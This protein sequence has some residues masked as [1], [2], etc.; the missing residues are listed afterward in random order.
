MAITIEPSELPGQYTLVIE[1]ASVSVGSPTHCFPSYAGAGFV[2]VLSRERDPLLLAPVVE[3]HVTEHA[4]HCAQSAHCPSTVEN[5]A[6]VRGKC[7][8]LKYRYL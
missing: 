5:S 6:I 1:Q 8:T 4:V 3:K 7:F 2:Q